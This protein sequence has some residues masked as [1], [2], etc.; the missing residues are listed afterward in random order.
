MPM[1]SMLVPQAFSSPPS[2]DFRGIH[3]LRKTVLVGN[4]GPCTAP[5]TAM[6]TQRPLMP[7]T[8]Q[9][10]GIAKQHSALNANAVVIT[11]LAPSWS[12]SAPPG[13]CVKK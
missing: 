2:G 3:R 6:I 5:M 10:A 12:A 8:S 11:F 4:K 1:S 13:T 9:L 7:S